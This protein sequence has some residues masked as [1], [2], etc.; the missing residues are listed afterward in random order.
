MY[1][2]VAVWLLYSPWGLPAAMAAHVLGDVLPIL[3]LRRNL[4][5]AQKA[6]RRALRK[7]AT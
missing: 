4:K 5:S 7:A 2:A 3:L 6:R 1:F